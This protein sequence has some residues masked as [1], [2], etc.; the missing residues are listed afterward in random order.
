MLLKFF[1]TLFNEI[2]YKLFHE[3]LSKFYRVFL[4]KYFWKLLTAFPMHFIIAI[5]TFLKEFYLNEISKF[6]QILRI[7]WGNSWR[8]FI[9]I[10]GVLSEIIIVLRS[11]ISFIR[12][13]SRILFRNSSRIHL[14]FS[15]ENLKNFPDIS[16]ETFHDE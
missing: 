13:Y 14:K 9:K 6:L 16:L 7:Y 5:Y 3:F 12:A 15:S 8:N 2:H 10:P 4:I 11:H 1:Q